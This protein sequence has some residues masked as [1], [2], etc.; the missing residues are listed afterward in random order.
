[1][2]ARLRRRPQFL[3]SASALDTGRIEAALRAISPATT[4][5]WSSLPRRSSFGPT[6]EP[7]VRWIEEVPREKAFEVAVTKLKERLSY[8][9]LLAGLFLAGIRNVKP[10]P[11]G[12]KFHAIL[13]MN[14]AHLLGQTA[15]VDDRL[16]PM[17]WSWTSWNSQAQDVKEGLDA[18]EGRRSSHSFGRAGQGGV[19]E[20]D[21][22]LGFR[23]R[24]RGGRRPLPNSRCR[25]G[26]GAPLALRRSRPARHRPQGDLRRPVLA[27]LANDRL[28]AC[29]AGLA[30][31]GFRYAR[32]SGRQQAR[33]RR[34][35][36]DQPRKRQ[37]DP[38]RLGRRQGRRRRNGFPPRDLPPGQ[39]R[40]S[41]GRGRQTAQSRRS[42]R[43]LWDAVVL[44]GNEMLLQAGS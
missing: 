25:G 6:S 31:A 30:V 13:V 33:C 11:V 12:F 43:L 22:R 15:S 19:R 32:P 23:C 28:A 21:G 17:F 9:D 2:D 41:V 3:Q 37:E 27:D 18:F 40:G 38:G 29:R 35:L 36:R 16:L 5:K 8:R 4:T 39:S 7:V 20:G 44:A 24:R 26:D 10:R 42:R 1:M 14:S 34:P